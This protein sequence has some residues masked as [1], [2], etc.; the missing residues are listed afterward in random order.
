MLLYLECPL[1]QAD[2]NLA[3]DVMNNMSKPFRAILSH[4]NSKQMLLKDK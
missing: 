2:S 3:L 1:I 4:L